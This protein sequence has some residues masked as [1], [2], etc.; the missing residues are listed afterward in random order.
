[1]IKLIQP[2]GELDIC[3]RDTDLEDA[4]Y[5]EQVR[6]TVAVA[7]R[8][9]VTRAKAQNMSYNQTVDYIAASF[10][11]LPRRRIVQALETLWEN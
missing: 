3:S 5:E 10:S 7:I 4:D 8:P 2:D 1:M 11:E 6:T 9:T